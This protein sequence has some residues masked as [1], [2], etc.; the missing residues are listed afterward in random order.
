MYKY[1]KEIALIQLVNATAQK[2]SCKYEWCVITIKCFSAVL[3]RAD[4]SPRWRPSPSFSWPAENGLTVSFPQGQVP[5]VLGKTPL[6]RSPTSLEI[7]PKRTELCVWS[8]VGNASTGMWLG[9][10]RVGLEVVL[11]FPVKRLLLLRL[12][13]GQRSDVPSAP[14]THNSHS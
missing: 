7:C 10:N 3:A 9:E 1:L 5:W 11:P 6:M 2:E 12:Q 4:L 8:T 13:W 14:L